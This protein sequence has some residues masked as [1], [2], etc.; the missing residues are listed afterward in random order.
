MLQQILGRLK[1][2][3]TSPKTEWAEIAGEEANIGDL[4]KSWIIPLAG[5][6]AIAGF[7]GANII[8]ITN[9]F[10]SVQPLDAL[11]LA[12]VS[13]LITLASVYVLALVIDALAP[14]F[15][16]EKNFGQAFK[17]AAYAPAAMWVAS[18]F[19]IVPWLGFLSFVGG[20][21][22]LYLLFVGLPILMK[23]AEDKAV[24]YTISAIVIMVVISIL[25]SVIVGLFYGGPNDRVSEQVADMERAAE[26]GDVAGMFDAMTSDV[27]GAVLVQPDALK[28]FMPDEV[29]GMAR[30]SLEVE[31]IAYPGNT[32][33]VTAKYGEADKVLTL[34][35]SNSKAIAMTQG[36]GAMMG[37][38]YDRETSDG[39]E[40]LQRDGDSW[41]KEDWSE[42]SQ[43]GEYSRTFGAFSISA[44]GR[45]LSMDDLEDAVNDIDSDDLTDLP[46]QE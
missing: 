42:A 3:L 5:L 37:A 40:R 8:A 24:T 9:R 14:T 32:T 11:L 44:R 29:D 21:Y 15:G 28:E 36:F 27:D 6:A 35:V 23:P 41:I 30:T 38:T 46:Q 34:T 39:Y 31:T 26:Q 20:I 43:R 1:P 22:S 10:I 18:L 2:L 4:Y 19:Q 25:G 12:I 7:I 45:N 17:V 13:L 16:A 33:I